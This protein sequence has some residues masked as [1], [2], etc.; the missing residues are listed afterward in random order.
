VFTITCSR[1]REVAEYPSTYELKIA[2]MHYQELGELVM[3]PP[4]AQIILDVRRPF[5]EQALDAAMN[6][7]E[8]HHKDNPV[9]DK[10]P[11]LSVVDSDKGEIH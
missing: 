8:Q 9:G 4:C 3:C 10:A 5:F 11:V 2:L 6:E 1:C 7:I